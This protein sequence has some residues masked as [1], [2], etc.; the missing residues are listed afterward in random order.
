[1]S[2]FYSTEKNGEQKEASQEGG[3]NAEAE[4]PLRNEIEQKEKEIIDLKVHH[5][6]CPR[7]IL[8]MN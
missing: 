6:L 2:R 5:S 4:D 8:C 7:A 3:E 1:M